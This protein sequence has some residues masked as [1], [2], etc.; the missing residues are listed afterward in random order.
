MAVNEKMQ[1]DR[2]EKMNAVRDSAYMNCQFYLRSNTQYDNVQQ[3]KELGSRIDKHWFRVTDRRYQNERILSIIPYNPKMMLPFTK[4]TCKTLKDLFSI[5]QHP[6]IF[7]MS[8][9][10]FSLEQKLVISVQPVS[11]KGSLK[12][13][14]Y[15]GRFTD[16]FYEKYNRRYKGLELGQVQI[17]GKQVLEG[18]LFM[19]EKSFPQHG[20][21]HSGNVMYDN[22]QCRL[23][24]FENS[25]IGNTS[26]V[27]PLIK[28][29][30]K[31]NKEALDTL[32]FGHLLFEMCCGYELD[33]A[34][35]EP[36]HLI[37]HQSPQIVSIL[38]FIFGIDTGRY[39]TIKQ[40]N[41]TSFL[42][43]DVF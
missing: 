40:V 8:D 33:S 18:L 27:H 35:P 16:S 28:K 3:L 30:L 9:F 39:P 7:P 4:L 34:H 5:L 29:K 41:M 26:R 37:G 31:D 6:H 17:F 42:S 14:I 32:C 20:S 21:V 15:Q 36:Q 43:T 38:N 19:Y 22:G 23:S 2:Q 13:L 10:D 1:R 25:F 24:G 12:D 11:I